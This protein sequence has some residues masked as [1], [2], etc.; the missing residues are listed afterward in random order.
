MRKETAQGR[1]LRA[2]RAGH[3]GCDRHCKQY[4]SIARE[5]IQPRV[6]YEGPRTPYSRLSIQETA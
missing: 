5:H 6:I 2:H 4:L 1:A 3:P